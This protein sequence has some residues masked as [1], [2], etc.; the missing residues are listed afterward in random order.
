MQIKTKKSLS[1]LI[2][3]LTLEVFKDE[4]DEATSTND[5]EGYNTPFAFSGKKSKKIKK[6]IAT[7]STGYKT[8]SEALDQEDL[9]NIKRTIRDEVANILRDIWL[10]RTSWK[11]K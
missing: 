6:R 8:V 2:K 3:N 5:I 7:N 10:K 4:L 1:N 9:K 11:G